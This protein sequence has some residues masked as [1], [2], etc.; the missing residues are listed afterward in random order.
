MADSFFL[1]APYFA[2]EAVR[3]QA[4]LKTPPALAL[5][6]HRVRRGAPGVVRFRLS[7]YSH[8]GIVLVHGSQTVFL[9]SASFGYGAA[10]FAI[11]PLARRGQYTVRLAATDLAGNFNRT[12]GTLNVY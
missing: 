9:T 8:V 5:L 2:V 11:P 7:K 10:A 6:T 3:A 1:L 12:V 4:Y